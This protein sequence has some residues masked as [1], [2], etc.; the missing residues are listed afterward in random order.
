MSD[1]VRVLWH[2]VQDLA[3]LFVVA[4]VVV[5][6]IVACLLYAWRR[7]AAEAEAYSNLSAR[8][9]I[10]V[11]YSDVQSK[12]E[13]VNEAKE[14]CEQNGFELDSVADSAHGEYMFVKAVG[15][16]KKGK[17]EIFRKGTGK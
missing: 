9:E 3:E 1:F 14:F 6:F 10:E 13:A 11:G 5:A 8:I 16:K 2:D 12:V 17:P 4:G 7:E 15:V